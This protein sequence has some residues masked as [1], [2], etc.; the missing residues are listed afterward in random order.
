MYQYLYIL[1]S[2]QYFPL[3][4]G[5]LFSTDTVEFKD[6][7]CR[8]RDLFFN[9]YYY[10]KGECKR[11][12]CHALT[13]T[14]TVETCLSK[15][16]RETCTLTKES[17]AKKGNFPLCCAVYTCNNQDI[18]FGM[19][20]T[21]SADSAA[22]ITPLGWV[23][24][25]SH[26]EAKTL[27]I[28]TIPEIGSGSYTEEVSLLVSFLL[29][30]LCKGFVYSEKDLTIAKGCPIFKPGI[31]Q[32]AM[33]KTEDNAAQY[34]ECCPVF[35]CPPAG[36]EKRVVTTNGQKVRITRD[37]CAY[38]GGRPDHT[39][40]TAK[41]CSDLN[42]KGK[43]NTDTYTCLDKKELGWPDCK[44]VSP[45]LH[46][47]SAVLPKCCEDLV[48]PDMTVELGEP[49]KSIER[50]TDVT[51]G[52]CTYQ[53]RRFKGT[54]TVYLVCEMWTC[55]PAERKVEVWRCPD[56]AKKLDKHCSWKIEENATAMFP[57]CCAKIVCH[58]Y[59]P[60]QHPGLKA[61]AS[62]LKKRPII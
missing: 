7:T 34:P 50:A 25:S 17:D 15:P 54:H 51:S 21:Y 53:N 10:P 45:G 35:M 16:T 20:T 30:S 57:H 8:Y 48:C 19:T 59:Y 13:K 33:I 18:Y 4:F 1:C 38:E 36:Y 52:V 26:W 31:H 9:S 58:Y 41:A 42:C 12:Q 60:T 28:P 3:T 39:L 2:I 43:Q 14:L 37:G 46:E 62:P 47:T 61:A 32:C 11:V 55:L 40:D 5:G 24:T 6:A 23:E 44:I 29:N 22:V 56:T 49:V 27:Y